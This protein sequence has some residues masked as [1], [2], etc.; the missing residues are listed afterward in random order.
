MLKKIA[1]HNFKCFDK[2]EIAL[3][4]INL[5]AGINSSGKSSAIQALLL[6]AN[7]AQK[8]ASSPLNGQWLRIGGFTEAR[9]FIRNAK[10]F[11]ISVSSDS[12]CF[13]VKF[14]QSE[15]DEKDTNVTIIENSSII[16]EL[17][18]FQNKHIYYLPATRLG[19]ADSYQMN[20]DR[21]NFLGNNGEF[22]VD[23]FIK[24]QNKN[25]LKEL[26]SDPSSNTLYSQ[27][28]Y[29]LY[30]LMRVNVL[31][32]NL[33]ISNTISASFSFNNNK[34][35]RPY[36]IGAGVSYI[37]SILVS[38]LS[39]NKKD[40]IIIENPEI[41]LHPKAQADLTEF[42]CF[43]SKAGIQI[44]LESHSDHIFNGLRKAISKKI[45]KPTHSSIN[46]FE[47]DENFISRNTLI[48]ISESGRILDHRKG[49]FDQFDEDLDQ[50]LGL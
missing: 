48:K 36:H 38:C 28:N 2:T 30:K 14:K 16:E 43:V 22:V 39:V 32:E 5:F 3:S 29:W 35:V 34:E 46:F 50:L 45:I 33:G 44:I 49:L 10:E 23:Y 8:N 6:V 24:N 12:N 19:P 26:I 31:I 18:D 13:S 20:F 42:L 41:H 37:L 4:N 9:N 47:L 40:I 21:V 17:L 27:V 7:N 1:I 11:N 25:V 15:D